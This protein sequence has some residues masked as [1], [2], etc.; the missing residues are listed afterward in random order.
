MKTGFIS[1]PFKSEKGD[2]LF[3]INGIGKFSPAGIVI[4]YESKFLG[5]FGGE[6]K[7]V[8]IGAIDIVDIKFKKGFLK[9]FSKI[10]IRLNNVAKL[11]EL[12]NRDGKF[13]MKIKREDFELGREAVEFFDHLLR[14]T[15]VADIEPPQSPVAELIES[16]KDKYKT[17][18]LKRTRKLDE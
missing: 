14:G 7:E 2:G 16:S 8:R 18:D 4:E 3:E 9:F 15:P 17:D 6:V 10:Q 1:V 13:T 12:P 5:M 11:S